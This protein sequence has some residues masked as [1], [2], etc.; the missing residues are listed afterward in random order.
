MTF[1]EGCLRCAVEVR[2]VVI[3]IDQSIV[4]DE[5]KEG[6]GTLFS[7]TDNPGEDT[8]NHVLSQRGDD[9]DM[10]DFSN[11][12][13]QVNLAFV[14]SDSATSGRQDMCWYFGTCYTWEP[15]PPP[16]SWR[17]DV[18][19]RNGQQAEMERV[20]TLSS[21][22]YTL[23]SDYE[24]HTFN[25]AKHP[26]VDV[27]GDGYT[28][29]GVEYDGF[30]GVDI[31]HSYYQPDRGQDYPCDLLRYNVN[32]AFPNNPTQ[33]VDSDN[34]GYGDNSSGINGDAFPDE[35]AQWSDVD[36]DGAGDNYAGGWVDDCPNRWGNSTLNLGGC[37]DAD[38]DGYSDVCGLE[39]CGAASVWT[40][41]G[42]YGYARG[43]TTDSCPSIP[44]ASYER[45]VTVAQA[46]TEMVGQIPYPMP[47]WASLMLAP[48]ST[49]GRSARIGE[50]VRTL[51]ATDGLMLKTTSRRTR[52]SGLTRTTTG[53]RT[54]RTT[55]LRII[56]CL[57]MKLSRWRCVG[58]SVSGLPSFPSCWGECGKGE[59][60]ACPWIWI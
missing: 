5:F 58:V 2:S 15:P 32:D 41:E 28:E 8:W 22:Q 33:W 56:S 60:R 30:C 17:V 18:E 25:W 31:P 55:I 12:V 39:W 48:T 29:P 19:L 14:Y 38:G 42:Q 43:D 24:L 16:V 51:T 1:S 26:V 9:Y 53:F 46:R 40:S 35:P 6:A 7:L 3:Q 11:V 54:K 34:D 44:G 4:H 52:N 21:E 20:V 45:R 37:P 36:G 59:Q 49:G 47:M 23:R 57:Q 27:D 50:G 13:L 10:A